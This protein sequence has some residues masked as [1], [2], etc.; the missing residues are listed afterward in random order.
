MRGV[1][2]TVPCCVAIGL[3]SAQ[4]PLINEVV[5]GGGDVPDWIEVYNPGPGTIDLQGYALVTVGRTHRI[6]AAMSVLSGGHQVLWCDRHPEEGP[7]HLDLKLPREGGSVLL[8][9]PDRSTLRDVYSWRALPSGVSIGRLRD[10]GKEWGYFT[11]PT[12]GASNA[13]AFGARRLLAAPLPDVQ[14]GILTCPSTEG[15]TFRYTLDGRIPGGSSTVLDGQ[16]TLT[17]PSIITLRAF[18]EDA[19]PSPSVALT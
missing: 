16:L 19:L 13:L 18:G 15:S 3:C 17:A 6:D 11:G 12:P 7:D 1:L 10:G 9:D 5:P 4:Q 14:D 2:S 8:I